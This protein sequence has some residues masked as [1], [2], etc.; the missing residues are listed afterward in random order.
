[1][2]PFDPD[3]GKSLQRTGTE[4]LSADIDTALTFVGLARSA[5]DDSGKKSRNQRNAR[6]AYDK[7]Q[8]LLAR[9]RLSAEQQR[10]IN[11]KLSHLKAELTSLGEH[12]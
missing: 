5:N 1:M 11:D 9:L 12:F 6:K 8:E 10:E 3:I 2:C 4:F 7:V